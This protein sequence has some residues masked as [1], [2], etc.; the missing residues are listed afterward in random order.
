MPWMAQ[1]SVCL[2]LACVDE[3][4][5]KD[6]NS[7]CNL[8]SATA[9]SSSSYSSLSESPSRM[10]KRRSKTSRYR[11]GELTNQLVKPVSPYEEL[12]QAADEMYPF[13]EF[14]PKSR[15]ARQDDDDERQAKR[16][17][18]DEEPRIPSEIVVT[19]AIP[20]FI[21]FPTYPTD[22]DSE[23][24]LEAVFREAVF[25]EEERSLT[26]HPSFDEGRPTAQDVHYL[27]KAC[28]KFEEEDWP[29]DED[30]PLQNP[31]DFC[32]SSS[33][34]DHKPNMGKPTET[35]SK[36]TSKSRRYILA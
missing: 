22:D 30:G 9:S 24:S 27:Y 7:S 10:V 15:Q 17:K 20:T 1:I 6:N 31:G 16:D 2:S 21:S 3:T 5:K 8:T 32:F 12:K 18:R 33:R 4:H 35:A 14:L 11:N 26:P 19:S 25:C 34:S 28:K 13:D 29:S 36:Q 23:L